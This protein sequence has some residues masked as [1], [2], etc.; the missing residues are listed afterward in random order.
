MR[1]G[2]Q[3]TCRNGHLR[4]PE[5]TL[6]RTDGRRG[7]K[8]YPA[9]KDC[10]LGLMELLAKPGGRDALMASF[11]AKYRVDTD[12]GCWVWTS[13]FN[14]EYAGFSVSGR[15][16]NATRVTW[17]LYHG[18]VPPRGMNI[19]HACD[20]PACVNPDHLFLGTTLDNSLDMVSK[21]RHSHGE[22]HP[23]AKL[24]EAQAAEI[25]AACASVTHAAL[26]SKYGVGVNAIYAIRN[27]KRWRHAVGGE[28]ADKL[29]QEL[30]KARAIIESQRERLA[31]SEAEILK[32]KG[33]QP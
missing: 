18:E 32:L 10:R 27:G 17:A 30:R 8:K 2:N 25:R 29:R 7:G 5:N 33:E 26:A 28:G 21:G 12:T 31:L 15:S 22:R 4:T 20:N 1:R 23:T 13:W 9:C 14:H 3:P 24:T 16:T 11:Q 6:M 19:C